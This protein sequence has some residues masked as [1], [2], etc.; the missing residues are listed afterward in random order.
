MKF[1]LSKTFFSCT[2]ARQLRTL[3]MGAVAVAGCCLLG[4]TASAD[5]LAPGQALTLDFSISSNTSDLL[6]FG[7]NDNAG[8]AAQSVIT[9]TLYAGNQ[10]LGTYTSSPQPFMQNYYYTAAFTTAS[11]GYTVYSPTVI[12]FSALNAGL[13]NGKAVFTV[14]GGTLTNINPFS[15]YVHDA[16]AEGS[17]GYFPHWNMSITN[18]EVGAA[19]APEPA[20]LGLIALSG[21]GLLAARRKFA[22]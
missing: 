19:N 11:S 22:K 14:T 16:S 17:D 18:S 1:L 15:F 9:T 10:L 12:D 8:L 6:L 4:G 7:I 2:F 5:T 13:S 21:L 3:A 20:S